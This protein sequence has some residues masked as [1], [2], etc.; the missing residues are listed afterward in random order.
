MPPV[1]GPELSRR[2]PALRITGYEKVGVRRVS[3]TLCEFDFRARLKNRGPAIAGAVGTI[4]R[5]PHRMKIV[6]GKVTFGPVASRG[7]AVSGDIFT[8]RQECA[9][10][11][12]PHDLLEGLRWDI[13]VIKATI[14]DL[15]PAE[16]TVAAGGGLGTLTVTIRNPEPTPMHVTLKSSGDESRGAG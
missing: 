11:C 7:G 3:R 10:R 13:A 2:D 16:L 6:D 15:E 12:D 4:I 9:I 8:V 5:W 14:A 1:R